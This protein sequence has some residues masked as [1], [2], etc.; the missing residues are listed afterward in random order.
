MKGEK[1]LPGRDGIDGMKGE[2][3]LPGQ[4]GPRVR[5]KKLSR[6]HSHCNI[7]HFIGKRRNIWP[8]WTNRTEGRHRKRWVRWSSRKARAKR[9]TRCTRK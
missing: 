9:R 1:G 3:G 2:K 5:I 4:P 7:A 6:P 8:T